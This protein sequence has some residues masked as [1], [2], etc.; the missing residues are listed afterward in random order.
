MN[1]KDY[2]SVKRGKLKVNQRYIELSMYLKDRDAM[3]LKRT[4]KYAK[5]LTGVVFG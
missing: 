4:K 5:M 1:A 2:C 3:R